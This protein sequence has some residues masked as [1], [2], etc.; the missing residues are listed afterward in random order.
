MRLVVLAA[1][2]VGSLLAA[3]CSPP[4]PAVCSAPQGSSSEANALADRWSQF[5]FDLYGPA[6][7]AAGAGHNAV[8][9]PFSVASTLTLIDVG[10]KG[11]T[12]SQLDKVL[13]L[14]SSAAEAAPD[15]AALSC[16]VESDGTSND[17]TMRVANTVFV[18]TGRRFD[19]SFLSVLSKGYAAPLQKTDFEHDAKGATDAIN[20]WVSTQT[21]DHIPHLLEPGDVDDATRLVLVDALYFKGAWDKGFDPA[22]T[23]DQPFTLSSGQVVQVPMMDG[24][25]SARLGRIGGQLLELDYKGGTVA[26]DFL[27]PDSSLS[28]FEATLTSERLDAMLGALGPKTNGEIR[29][30]K[31]SFSTRLGL[32]PVLTKMGV[33]DVF[34][35]LKADLSGIDG[36]RDLFV[37]FVIHQATVEVDE[38]GTVAT[39]A[40][41]GGVEELESAGPLPIDR[42]FV[43]LVRDTKTGA[44]LFVGHVEDPRQN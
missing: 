21:D 39:A 42:P 22:R 41:A 12:E 19:E 43:F 9:S 3:G 6:V 13:H 44:L 29:L 30:P 32:T 4:P 11:E 10:A 26:M 16:G 17:G 28:E 25:V 31:F 23:S 27:M 8:L 7:D 20:Q 36:K 33:T 15:Y 1:A 18:Q 34:D 14:P 38:Q 24:N 40:T 37:S 2:V 5:G 35:P